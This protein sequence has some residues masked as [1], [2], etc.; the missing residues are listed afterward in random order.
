MV[1]PALYVVLVFLVAVTRDFTL[2]YTSKSIVA[3]MWDSYHIEFTIRKQ[4]KVNAG[5][6]FLS[7]FYSARDHSPWLPAFRVGLPL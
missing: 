5:I 7:P 3:G 6:S 2:A 4:R 1:E